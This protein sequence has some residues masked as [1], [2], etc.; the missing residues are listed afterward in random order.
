MRF[1]TL[2]FIVILILF[3]CQ[4]EPVPVSKPV[5]FDK[6]EYAQNLKA[7][8]DSIQSGKPLAQKNNVKRPVQP[9]K[10]D[11]ITKKAEAEKII[12]PPADSV[13]LTIIYGKAK[14]DTM[15]LARQKVVFEFDSNTANYL[16][17]KITPADS[18]ANLRISQIIAPSGK[19]DGPF[20][21][22]IK[23]PITEKGIYK[24]LVSESLMNG[25]P[26]N[27]RFLFEVKLGW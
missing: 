23:Y 24:V 3:S 22:E 6:K 27:G 21:N 26:Y 19:S 9:I 13:K 16:N 1:G 8:R 2:I 4:T 10:T 18:L 14:A 20:G 15:K 25:E 17:L 7:A 5:K 12:E 11:S